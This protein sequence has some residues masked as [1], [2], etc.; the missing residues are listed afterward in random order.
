MNDIV[1]ISITYSSEYKELGKS[2]WLNK[3]INLKMIKYF[4]LN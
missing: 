1:N 3:N 2:V 4:V